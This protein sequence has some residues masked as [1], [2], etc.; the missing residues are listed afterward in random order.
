M[1]ATFVKIKLVQNHAEIQSNWQIKTWTKLQVI[2]ILHFNITKL[3][4]S[5]AENQEFV[6]PIRGFVILPVD[7]QSSIA[8]EPELVET[9]CVILSGLDFRGTFNVERQMFYK[10]SNEKNVLIIRMIKH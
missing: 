4:S 6:T 5:E 8:N 2:H 7:L 1:V 3:F 9:V 10:C